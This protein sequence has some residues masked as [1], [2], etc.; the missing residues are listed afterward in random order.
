MNIQFSELSIHSHMN[1]QTMTIYKL[2]NP[3]ELNSACTVIQIVMMKIDS[4]IDP[5]L[6]NQAEK[7]YCQISQTL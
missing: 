1:A 5:I 3:P 2:S 6:V 4:T 7:K